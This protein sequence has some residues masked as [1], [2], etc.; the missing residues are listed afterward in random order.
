MENSSFF[1]KNKASEL[2]EQACDG[3]HVKSCQLFQ[4]E[5]IKESRGRV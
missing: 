2:L 5:H 3:G 1:S 4:I